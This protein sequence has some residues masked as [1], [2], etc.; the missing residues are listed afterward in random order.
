MG[1]KL[2]YK[3]YFL[4]YYTAKKAFSKKYFDLSITMTW[5]CLQNAIFSVLS[6]SA[7]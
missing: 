3:G 5:L 2:K 4:I 1:A 6:T 7:L